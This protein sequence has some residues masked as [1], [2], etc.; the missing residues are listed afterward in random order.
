MRITCPNCTAS[1]EIPT[2]LLGKKGRSLKCASCGHSWYQTPHVETI[3]LAEIMGQEYAA[4][5]KADMGPA[6]P[7]ARPGAPPAA[8]AAPGQPARPLAPG[9]PPA[10][11]AAAPL[12]V[13][14]LQ[15]RPGA[16]PQ[17]R[18][19]AGQSWNAGV[20]PP[21]GMPGAPARPGQPAT[22]P[23]QPGAAPSWY[24]PEKPQK[25]PAAPAGA[26][27]WYQP[28]PATQR[29]AAAAGG[30]PGAPSW[31][32]PDPA[33]QQVQRPG[34]MQHQ[35]DALSR[36]GGGTLAGP[37]PQAPP[38]RGGGTLAANPTDPRFQTAAL[39]GQSMRGQAGAG[40]V[41]D[42]AMSWVQQ[43]AHSRA[44]RR[45][46]WVLPVFPWARPEVRRQLRCAGNR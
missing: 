10:A 15:K 24:Q 23:G 41:G 2:E 18:G 6:A 37:G 28:D 38:M 7:A 36:L 46:Q 26:P 5:A 39:S 13:S 12:G 27:S 22:A 32:Q 21:A 3:D 42:A 33:T 34:T 40:A 4:R 8:V 1:F 17:Q 35:P 29:P 20:T 14:L 19:Q 9:A 45:H 16:A 11:A 31:Y 25:I 44:C 30:V 43:P